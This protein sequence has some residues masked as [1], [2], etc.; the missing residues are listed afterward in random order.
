MCEVHFHAHARHPLVVSSLQAFFV[1]KV[2]AKVGLDMKY[3]HALFMI[4]PL[5]LAAC[6]SSKNGKKNDVE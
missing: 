3:V 2:A 4:A 5:I 1:L 6:E